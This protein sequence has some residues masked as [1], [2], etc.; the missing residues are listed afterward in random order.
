MVKNRRKPSGHTEIKRGGNVGSDRCSDVLGKYIIDVRD[1]SGPCLAGRFGFGNLDAKLVSPASQL[2]VSPAQTRF[3]RRLR[4]RLVLELHDLRRAQQVRRAAG[5]HF[6]RLA[7]ERANAVKASGGPTRWNARKN[8][9]ILNTEEEQKQKQK[10]DQSRNFSHALFE[11]QLPM[12]SFSS[13]S[14][15]KH[16]EH[17]SNTRRKSGNIFNTDEE[18]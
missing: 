7:Y 16:H 8:G 17:M 3:C 9:N 12:I 4:W 14:S 10:I 2:V 11:Y 13:I 18:A 15:S 1:R 6:K 5:S